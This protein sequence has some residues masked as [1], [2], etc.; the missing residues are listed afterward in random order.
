MTMHGEWWG[1]GGKG[2]G[3]TVP[4]NGRTMRYNNN[5]KSVEKQH[6]VVRG[7]YNSTVL[8][9]E[10]STLTSVPYDAGSHG[11]PTLVE[12]VAALHPVVRIRGE[13]AG[14]A[15]RAPLFRGWRR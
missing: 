4:R 5:T 10:A 8:D 12:V 9:S 1:D 3:C 15:G 13:G 14:T 7:L 2:V 11:V 6:N